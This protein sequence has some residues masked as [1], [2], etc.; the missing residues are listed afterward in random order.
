MHKPGDFLTVTANGAIAARRIVDIESGKSASQAASKT[1]ANLGVSELACSD[2]DSVDVVYTGIVEVEAGGDINHGDLIASDSSG[3][4]V[5]ANAGDMVLG[6]A[7]GGASAGEYVSVRISPGRSPGDISNALS[8]DILSSYATKAELSDYATSSSL[9]SYATKA[10]LSDC[11][12][13]SSLS[14]Y[15]TK[16]ELSDYATSSSLS[17]YATKAELSD[18][19]TSSSL[20]SYATKAELSDYATSSS[21]SS[22]A[23]KAELSDYATSSSLSSY[24]TKAELSDY[25]TSSSLSSYATKAELSDC[26]T[27]SSLSSYATKAELSDYATSSSL[28]SYA[29]K[30]ELSDYA[31]S[32]SLSSYATK[33]ELSDYATSSSLSSYATKAELSD[34][35]TSS[36]LSSYAT[37]A[38]LSGYAPKANKYVEA[39]FMVGSS[40][41]A[42]NTIVCQT[43]GGDT[44][45]TAA[46]Y[47][48]VPVGVTLE[49][50][51]AN[52]SIKVAVAGLAEVIVKPDEPDFAIGDRVCWS[53][54]LAVHMPSSAKLYVG[55]VARKLDNNR[56]VILISPGSIA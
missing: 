50:S 17:S 35:A 15:A 54:G 21:L 6:V 4:A 8:S 2:G 25:A 55:M 30:A 42:A 43:V 28:S 52:Q 33:A 26:A 53:D 51:D 31:T 13:S 47:N 20:S 48:R 49:S 5:A 34:Y 18:Y 27:S 19:A 7:I 9:S 39:T 22:Y 1:A 12:T 37:K 16:A 44:V 24:A 14:S 56:I 38:E 40:S 46:Y 29:T 32:S 45:H 36:S 10:E 11:A 23:T 3:K 41:I